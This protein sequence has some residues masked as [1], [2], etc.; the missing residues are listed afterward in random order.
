[1]A[2]NEG[3]YHLVFGGKWGEINNEEDNNR[4]DN[5]NYCNYR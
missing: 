5:D 3:K 2:M 1:M 4:S